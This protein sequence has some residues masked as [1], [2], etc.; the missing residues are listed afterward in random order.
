MARKEASS[1]LVDDLGGLVDWSAAAW[2][3]K[4]GDSRSVLDN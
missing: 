2:K 4:L 1:L 3:K